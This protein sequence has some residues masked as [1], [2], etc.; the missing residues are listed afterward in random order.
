MEMEDGAAYLIATPE[1]ALCDMVYKTPDITSIASMNELLIENWRIE[2]DELLKL[3]Y[4]FIEW[5]APLY[6]RKS[7]N[8]L[9]GWFTKERKI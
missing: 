8:A 2:R 4:E 9:C 1:K 6:H 3:D 7:L 5:I